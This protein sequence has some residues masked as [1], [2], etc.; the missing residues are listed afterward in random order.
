[1]N[2]A[3]TASPMVLTTAPFSDEMISSSAWK[4]ARTRSKAARSPTRSYSAVDPFRSVN[5]NVRDV[6]FSRWSMLRLSALKTSRNV[7]LVSIRLAVRNGFRF[8]S[9]RWRPSAAMQTDG[10]TRVPV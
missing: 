8:P 4:C 7:W 9:S 3:I 1:M 6:I 10:S 5:R 2:V